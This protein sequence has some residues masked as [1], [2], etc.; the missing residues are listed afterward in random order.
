MILAID[1][2]N[3]N[4]VLGCADSD[5]ILFRE[6]LATVQ[7]ETSLE[8]AVKINQRRCDIFRRTVCHEHRKGGG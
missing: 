4:I 2:G 7:R 1:I 3:T 5:R 6:R 8:Y